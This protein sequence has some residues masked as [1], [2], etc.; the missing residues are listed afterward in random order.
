MVKLAKNFAPGIFYGVR[1][2]PVFT[3]GFKDMLGNVQ[4][5]IFAADN[6]I[7]FGRNLTLLRDEPFLAAFNRHAETGPE[8]AVMWRVYVL[9]WAAQ[10]G[11]RREG[12][13]V[14]CGSYKGTSAR[15]V[16]DYVDFA[17]ETGRRFYLYDLFE[18]TDDMSHHAMP[19]HS[20]GLFAQVTERFRNVPNAVVTQG[21]V[22]DSFE[23][24]VPNG[25]IA[26][27]H[28]DMNNRDAEIGALE[29]LFDQVVPGGAIVFDDYGW[30][31]YADQQRAEDRFMADRGYKILELP[32]GQGLLI[33]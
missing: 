25:P 28:I 12:D 14:E 8:K 5:G 7:T 13:F 16:C 22:P 11:L 19:E 31:G 6:L 4:P 32:T 26:F 17:S 23:K 29:R 24:A 33:K 20:A 15:I 1:N 18:H 21:P 3:R 30:L 2:K 9:C 27:L 10:H